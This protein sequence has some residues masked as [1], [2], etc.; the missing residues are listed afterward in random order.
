M[1]DVQNPRYDYI[2]PELVSLFVT[3]LYARV[4]R[5]KGACVNDDG[6]TDT[7]SLAL[8]LWMW[9]CAH[10]GERTIL[11]TSTAFWPSTTIPRTTNYLNCKKLW[12]CRHQYTRS[13]AYMME[14]RLSLAHLS[15]VEPRKCS[16]GYASLGCLGIVNI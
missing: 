11:R 10:V 6:G 3:N 16:L 9:V 12:V 15:I 4:L 14:A 8:P 1:V 5:E 13:C 2:P 7:C